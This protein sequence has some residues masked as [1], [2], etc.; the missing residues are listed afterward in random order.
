M[1]KFNPKEKLNLK[2]KVPIESIFAW[3]PHS[4]EIIMVKEVIS[5]SHDWGLA[6]IDRKK[7]QDFNGFKDSKNLPVDYAIELMAQAQGMI[8]A[9]QSEAGLVDRSIAQEAYVTGLKDLIFYKTIL[10]IEEP[11]FVQIFETREIGGFRFCNVK[12]YSNKPDGSEGLVVEG[13][14]KTFSVDKV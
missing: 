14:M 2:G 13:V 7:I 11:L 5:V 4:D 10:N 3:L 6:E 8:G 12:I 1:L 9:A